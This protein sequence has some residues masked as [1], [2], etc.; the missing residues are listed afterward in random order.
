MWKRN[1][2]TKNAT[3]KKLEKETNQHKKWTKVKSKRKSVFEN[4]AV[5]PQK[6][7]S[8]KTPAATIKIR[9]KNNT[10]V[11]VPCICWCHAIDCWQNSHVFQTNNEAQF[12]KVSFPRNKQKS[13][14]PNNIIFKANKK[15]TRVK[16]AIKGKTLQW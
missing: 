6:K 9:S 11:V 16:S 3:K 1:K 5:N 2:Q 14:T 4:A 7:N 13:R 12:Q 10:S 15:E 8:T